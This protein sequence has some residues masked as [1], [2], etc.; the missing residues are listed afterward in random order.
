MTSFEEQVVEIHENERCWIGKGFKQGGLLPNDRSRYS[1]TDGSMSWKTL[2]EVSRSPLLLGTGWIYKQEEENDGGT[3]ASKPDTMD[4]WMYARD[5][6]AEAVTR[7]TPTRGIMDW[8]R[9]RSLT[10]TK[11]LVPEQLGVSKE[12]YEQCDHCDSNACES[13]SNLLLETLAYTTLLYNPSKP[14][15]DA[16]ALPL[17]NQIL[18]LLVQEQAHATAE[19]AQ[20]DAFYRLTLL[21]TALDK[22][23]QTLQSQ[24]ALQR[25]LSGIDYSFSQRHNLT[26]VQAKEFQNRC[27]S[28]TTKCFA[29]QERDAIAG[30]MI[31][32]LDYLQFQLHCNR[33]NCG[34]ACNFA[35][36]ICPN[37]GCLQGMSKMYLTEHDSTCVYKV[38][39]CT[40]GDLFPRHEL[41]H[42]QSQL[43]K[44]RDV[45]CPFAKIGCIKVVQAQD[46][47]DHVQKDNESHLLLAVN[48][49]MEYEKVIR[50]MKEQMQKMQQENQLLQRGLEVYRGSSTKEQQTLDSKVTSLGKKLASLETTSK[51]EFQKIHREFIQQERSH[52]K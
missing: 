14:T 17:K 34:E 48:R 3:F 23:C 52:A 28:L 11:I 44:L 20:Q 29:K 25:L 30:W 36:V 46:M 7:A 26:A 5:F 16:V 9:F 33:V 6:R 38:V 31:R 24:T 4:R 40:C 1:T 49:M 15:T 42:H 19:P 50:G 45:K 32:K 21:E 13:L 39:P 27:T 18:D 35:R 22:F 43:C 51:K 2:E 47:P 10:R 12:I 41:P 37:D 8:V